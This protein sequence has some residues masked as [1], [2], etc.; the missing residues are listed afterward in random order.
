MKNRLLIIALVFLTNNLLA[1]DTGVTEQSGIESEITI[2]VNPANEDEIII[3]SM[4]SN[5]PILIYTSADGGSSWSQSSFGNG[6]ADPVLTYGD[7][8]TA[9][10]TFLDFDNT[11]E[12]SL[13]QSTD[14]GLNWD[15]DKLTLD[16]MAA[17]RQWIKRD[18]FSNSPFYGNIYLSYFHPEGGRDI[19]VVKIDAA[20]SVG[21][22][23][24]IHTTAYDYVQN[25]AIDIA[26][27]GA[28]VICFIAEDANGNR[29]IVSVNSTDGTAT[30]SSESTV[31]TIY[32]FENGN[33]VADV[34]GFAPGDASRLGNSL[35]LAM[36]K[37]TGPYAG[38]AYIT[39]TDFTENNPEEG[40][41]IYLS[42]SDDNGVSWSIPKIVNDDN[43]ASSH[44][45]YSGI[46]VNPLGIVC[47]SWYDR[48]SDPAK[49][50]LTDFYFT[51]SADGGENFQNSV[52]V[53]S[54]TSDHAAVTDGLVTFGVGE[55]T[56]LA[57]TFTDSYVVWSDGRTN[58]GDMD[59]YFA[60]VSLDNINSINEIQLSPNL[61]IENLFPNPVS[62]KTIRLTLNTL[63][64]GEIEVSI[65]TTNGQIVSHEKRF[66]PRVGENTI[67]IG[68]QNFPS[69]S[70]IVEIKYPDGVAT[71]KFV[72]E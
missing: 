40:M 1:Q 41:N 50:A 35:Q 42:F 28:V 63:F 22:N 10:L 47:L 61:I 45:Y 15:I 53:N 70:Y 4:G 66:L 8:N 46:D 2:A 6:I 7:N 16:G 19:H 51:C 13:A 71:K 55:Y 12:M 56:S 33:P 67:P 49:D 59:V 54:E 11:L 57:T 23:H 58:D 21:T 32:M 9:Y 31:S 68:L 34:V 17:D 20:G 24:P 44:Q 65:L 60:K 64:T 27:T 39:W 25:P 14:A 48:R 5:S 26:P 37:S 69:G 29:K 43:V 36:D 18:N 52:K 3:A 62:S 38:R 30:F 72:V